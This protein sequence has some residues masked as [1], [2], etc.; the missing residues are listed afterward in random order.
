MNR[1]TSVTKM[2]MR[3]KWM[4]FFV[5]WIVLLS[6]FG[7]NLIIGYLITEKTGVYTGGLTSIFIYALIAGILSLTQMFPFA[8]GLSVRRIDFFLGT[9]IMIGLS[10]AVSAIVLFLFSI[11]ERLTGSWGVNLHFFRL[12]YVNDGN[13]FEQLLIY[14]VL[15][16]HLFTLG[17]VTSSIARRFGKYGLLSFFAVVILLL[18]ILSILCT[19]YSWWDDIFRFMSG[20]TAFELVLFTIPGTILYGLVSYLLLRKATV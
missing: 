4:W 17:F 19:H 15:L 11:M 8:L 2:H 14:F 1:T 12:P 20:H 7:I 6:S 3:D 5:P 10:S 16:V 13:A 18:G 9:M